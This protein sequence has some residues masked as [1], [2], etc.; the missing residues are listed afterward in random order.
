MRTR[1]LHRS[2]NITVCCMKYILLSKACSLCLLGHT[3]LVNITVSQSHQDHCRIQA[4]MM[5]SDWCTFGCTFTWKD[6]QP[7]LCPTVPSEQQKKLKSICNWYSL[8][9]MQSTEVYKGSYVK[10]MLC[11]E[12]KLLLLKQCVSHTVLDADISDVYRTTG[13]LL[14]SLHSIMHTPWKLSQKMIRAM[15]EFR[16]HCRLPM[17]ESNPLQLLAR[18]LMAAAGHHRCM[19]SRMQAQHC[20]RLGMNTRKSYRLQSL[21]VKPCKCL[22]VRDMCQLSEKPLDR[23]AYMGCISSLSKSRLQSSCSTGLV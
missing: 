5:S 1:Q 3:C 13:Q 6:L 18:S 4:V 15:Q 23:Q 7:F 14:P 10:S 9:K 19:M 2:A 21:I 16:K 20:R 12:R 22:C 11:T 17:L 8:C